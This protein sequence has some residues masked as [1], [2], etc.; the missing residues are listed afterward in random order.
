MT[1]QTSAQRQ[2]AFKAS[3]RAAGMVRLEAYVS[4]KERG[5]YQELGGVEWLRKKINAGK[6]KET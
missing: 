1:A 2:Q 4:R 5:K 6:I 3:R